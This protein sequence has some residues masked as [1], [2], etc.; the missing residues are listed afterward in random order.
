M[1]SQNTA[2]RG[3]AELRILDF[4]T[5]WSEFQKLSS[6]LPAMQDEAE[7][8]MLDFKTR[9]SEF[10]KP[11]QTALRQCEAERS[12]FNLKE[13]SPPQSWSQVVVCVSTPRMYSRSR[14]FLVS[15]KMIWLLEP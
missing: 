15:L 13:T 5:T 8:R 7:L 1:P 10:Q 12:I 9:W 2:D 4:K 6:M 14:Y 11:Y 3:K